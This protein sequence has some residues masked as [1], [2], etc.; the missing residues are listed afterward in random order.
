MDTGRQWLGW[1]WLVIVDLRYSTN[2]RKCTGHIFS[3]VFCTSASGQLKLYLQ[4]RLDNWTYFWNIVFRRFVQ[5]LK[6]LQLLFNICME[7]LRY[8][9]SRTL[10]TSCYFVIITLIWADYFREEPSKVE[11]KHH[12]FSCALPLYPIR[13][14]RT[15]SMLYFE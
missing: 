9:M 5:R 7:I 12:H 1:C 6:T 10:P 3:M 11:Y 15:C 14:K 2:H 8:C 13:E 4:F